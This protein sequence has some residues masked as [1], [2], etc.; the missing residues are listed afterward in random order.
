M[1]Y[2]IHRETPVSTVSRL[3]VLYNLWESRAV[4]FSAGPVSTLALPA[5]RSPGQFQALIL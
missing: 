3:S 2:Q 1:Q 5:T 4:W